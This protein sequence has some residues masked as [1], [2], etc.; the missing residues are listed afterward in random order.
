MKYT[1]NASFETDTPDSAE[2]ITLLDDIQKI[3]M[4]ILPYMADNV[5]VTVRCHDAGICPRCGHFLPNDMTPGAYPGALSRWDNET[6]ICSR[7]GQQEAFLDFAAGEYRGGGAHL[8]PWSPD[9]P[10]VNPPA[11]EE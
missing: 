5:N 4:N 8:A 6:E 11:K 7:C 2:D 9:N 10:W 1:L 3:L